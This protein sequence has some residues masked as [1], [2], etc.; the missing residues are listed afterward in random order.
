MMCGGSA[1]WRCAWLSVW[2]TFSTVVTVE[3]QKRP[4]LKLSALQTSHTE[5]RDKYRERLNG[6]IAYCRE[7]QLADGVDTAHKYRAALTGGMM[8][9][10]TL[11]ATFEPDLP[12][13]LTPE[14]REWQV[15]LRSHRKEYAKDLYLLSRRAV[16]NGHPAFAFDLVREIVRHDP[17]HQQARELLGFVSHEQRWV[18]PQAKALLRKGHVWS[19]DFGWIPE[20]DLLRYQ[21]G[22][23]LVDG[24]WMSREKEAEIRRDFRKAWE[25]RTDH[26]LIRTNDSLERG[27]ELGLALED[28]HQFFHQTFAAF[29]ASPDQ[30]QQLFNGRAK[31]GARYAEPY[32]I[33]FYRDRE[34]YVSR[35]EPHFKFIDK[36]NGLYLPSGPV[37][38]TAHFYHDPMGN[39]EA[40]LF[41]E[42]THQLFYESFPQN[43][44]IAEKGHFWIIEGVACYMESFQ[45]RNGEL[46]VGD[47]QYIRFAGARFN[48]I[49]Q[50]YYVPLQQFAQMG[51]QRFQ[52]DEMLAKNYTQASGLV[53][54]FMHYDD[55]RYRDALIAQLN[56]LYSDNPRQREYPK[57]L[58]E[59]TGE[60]F[61]ELDRLYGEYVYDVA[62]KLAAGTEVS[63]P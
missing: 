46:S 19:K 17:D 50:K 2:L 31:S 23:R 27:V 36:T 39:H 53:H 20:K 61:G 38:R 10:V 18:T 5:H 47:P 44:P 33:H 34:E 14:Q 45:R 62:R 49:D 60:T 21:K 43:R 63:A 40:T 30:L 55:G 59:L 32:N 41:H 52:A 29:F 26:Y 28:F 8:P 42:A 11:P 3:A 25:V 13:S 15:Q 9:V 16:N 57:E 6:V 48:F 37:A 24:R 35:L 7:H 51:M 1:G 54:F 56:Q 12:A 58:D 22:E 4:N